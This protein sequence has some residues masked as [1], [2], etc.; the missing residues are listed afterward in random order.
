MSNHEPS[1]VASTGA[2]PLQRCNDPGG[3]TRPSSVAPLNFEIEFF[4]KQ[5]IIDGDANLLIQFE[6]EDLIPVHSFCHRS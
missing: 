5:V 2:L 3:G 1:D 4:Y 6:F